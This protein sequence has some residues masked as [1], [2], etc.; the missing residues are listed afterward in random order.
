M[1]ADRHVRVVPFLGGDSARTAIDAADLPAD[2]LAARARTAIFKA[3]HFLLEEQQTDGHFA[4][5]L[6]GPGLP[7]SEYVLLMAY[8]GDE[9]STKT[10]QAAEYVRFM[11]LKDGGWEAYHGGGVDVSTSVRAYFALKLTGVDPNSEEMRRACWAIRAAGGVEA[12]DEVTRLYL[13][14]LGQDRYEACP[15]P[16]T[17]G[18]LEAAVRIVRAVKPCRP[19][20]PA[21]GIS[22][23]RASTTADAGSPTT[24]TADTTSRRRSNRAARLVRAA[25]GRWYKSRR[26]TPHDDPAV[27]QAER[28]VLARLFAPKSTPLCFRELLWGIVALKGLGYKDDS[29]AMVCAMA[30]LEEHLYTE[31]NRLRVEPMTTPL[32]DTA[33]ALQALSASGVE[34]AHAAVTN[35]ARWL[36]ARRVPEPRL[37]ISRRGEKSPSIPVGWSCLGSG[38]QEAD[39]GVTAQ[40][41]RALR[42]SFEP[43][44]SESDAL[45]PVL[46]VVSETA[47]GDGRNDEE[48]WIALLGETIDALTWTESWLLGTQGEDGG[49]HAAPLR[50]Q[51]ERRGLF[52]TTWLK[53]GRTNHAVEDNAVE[54]TARVLKAL[55][56][57]GRRSDDGHVKRAVAW[58]RSRQQ[59][60]GSWRGTPTANAVRDTAQV[61]S[62]LA[63]AGISPSDDAVVV[64]VN[65]LLVHQ[66]SNGGWGD[67]GGDPSSVSRER[68]STTVT[69]TAWAVLGLL[70]AG[71]HDHPAVDSGIRFL[72]DR[73]QADGTWT[74]PEFTAGAI[75]TA[76]ASEQPVRRRLL[77]TCLSLM[78]LSAW[79]KANRQEGVETPVRCD[80]IRE[81]VAVA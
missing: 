63:A 43:S 61:L 78:A 75:A 44:S 28:T 4:G 11:Q 65:W 27:V 68:D 71:R 24:L 19:I 62:G 53:A 21:A 7:E 35:A 37:Q 23:L 10:R 30:R 40:V 58:L 52:S 6:D 2:E 20:P 76:G 57:L 34:P 22:E 33:D 32:L 69:H 56:C 49:W 17:G 1:K 5:R 14:L 18:S 67:V 66:R 60:D 47:E 39:V 36:L 41:A 29:P 3:R 51:T 48:S 45:P 59:A 8:L 73:Q 50:G 42:T 64:A 70:A 9:R 74:E 72:V 55:G 79:A 80:D 31:E 38:G 25:I 81:P 16:A 12:V 26:H 54:R 13:A 15:A 46:N 77:P